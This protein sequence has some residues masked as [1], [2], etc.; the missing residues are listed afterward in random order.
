MSTILKRFSK[1]RRYDGRVILIELTETVII[2]GVRFRHREYWN[3]T[4]CDL[5]HFPTDL[6]WV[7]VSEECYTVRS[8]ATG[9]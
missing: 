8:S 7:V 3:T 4:K 6:D 2:S 5:S 9:C 1:N